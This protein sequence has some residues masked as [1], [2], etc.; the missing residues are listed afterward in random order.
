MGV[1]GVEEGQHTGE[2][3]KFGGGGTSDGGSYFTEGAVKAGDGALPLYR[4]QVVGS[5]EHYRT[6]GGM[7]TRRSEGLWFW[8]TET[9]WDRARDTDTAAAGAA[10]GRE[11]RQ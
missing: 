5:R 3:T 4:C 7:A 6:A 10:C 8:K 11:G 2:G 9:Q 1:V